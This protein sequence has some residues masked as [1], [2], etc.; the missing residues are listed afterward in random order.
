MPN[1]KKSFLRTPFASALL[2]GAIVAVFGWVAI[3]AGW[4][5]SEGGSTTTVAAPLAAPVVSHEKGESSAT[6]VNQI[7][8]RDGDGVAFIESQIEPQQSETPSP[9][10]PFGEPEQEGGGIATGSGF[11]I[12]DEGHVLTNN[13]VI[14]GASKVTPAPT[15]PC[16][17]STH[18]RRN[19]IR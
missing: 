11:V 17:R 13:H 10:N 6:V 5:Q 19:S 14:E 7:Y 2:G 9:F 18:P 16:S 12:D 1:S 3:A 4:I 8:K 15:S